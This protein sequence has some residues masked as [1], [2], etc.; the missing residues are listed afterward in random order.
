M[1][2]HPIRWNKF[3]WSMLL[4]STVLFLRQQLRLNLLKY[5]LKLFDK[6]YESSKT[7]SI[8]VNYQLKMLTIKAYITV[9]YLHP[10]KTVSLHTQVAQAKRAVLYRWFFSFKHCQ[11]KAKNRFT[12]KRHVG[13]Q[14]WKF[15]LFPLTICTS[16]LH[17]LSW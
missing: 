11:K 13:F 9:R 14:L 1:C 2:I 12:T 6:L 3:S 4:A 16:T 10:N 8:K 15:C 5:T 17:L 7:S